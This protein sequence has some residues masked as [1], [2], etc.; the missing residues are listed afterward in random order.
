M[1]GQPFLNWANNILLLLKQKQTTA[2]SSSCS[3]EHFMKKSKRR[4]LPLVR[5]GSLSHYCQATC[6]AVITNLLDL[7]GT[8]PR[9]NMLKRVEWEVPLL[10]TAGQL[11]EFKGV[12][13]AER[14]LIPSL[15]D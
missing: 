4:T 13:E 12:Y 6:I 14:L 9:G 1:T 8:Y 7:P 2:E 11:P 5:E 3:D 10:P 15:I